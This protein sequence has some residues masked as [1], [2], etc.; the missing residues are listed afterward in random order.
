MSVAAPLWF[1][2]FQKKILDF[3]I[4][5]R[6]FEFFK[7]SKIMSYNFLSRKQI[8]TLRGVYGVKSQFL[9]WNNKNEMKTDLIP[10]D[11]RRNS[12]SYVRPKSVFLGPKIS[13]FFSKNIQNLLKYL[14]FI[15]EKST[16]LFAQLY[17]VMVWTKK[18]CFFRP[19]NSDFG[20]KLR[21]FAMGPRILSI[22]LL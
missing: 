15:W 2:K 9:F 13:Y 10:E 16:F 3:G 6:N 18:C 5:F 14:I 12:C 21:F 7:V 8:L 4:F 11:L 17:P 19:K 20:P 1:W 22:A